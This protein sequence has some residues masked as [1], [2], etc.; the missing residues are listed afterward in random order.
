MAIVYHKNGESVTLSS[1]VSD[2][3]AYVWKKDG[4]PLE[5]ETAK[6]YTIASFSAET[7]GQ[8]TVEATHDGGP[9]TDTFD[10]GLVRLNGD[11]VQSQNLNAYLGAELNLYTTFEVTFTPEPDS[12]QA[13]EYNITYQWKNTAGDISGETNSTLTIN[14]VDFEDADTYKVVATLNKTGGGAGVVESMEKQVAVVTVTHPPYES[15]WEVHPLKYR[16]SS[17]TWVGYWVIDEI[18]SNPNWY[19][20]PSELKYADEVKTLLAAFD[21]HGEVEIQESRNG[22]IIKMSDLVAAATEE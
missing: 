15:A 20:N 22:R 7:V 1:T 12:T 18:N 14:P 6:D 11:S 8:Y 17:F 4:S 2:A 16:D 10:L 9:T 3:T 21:E 13:D 5:G 19:D